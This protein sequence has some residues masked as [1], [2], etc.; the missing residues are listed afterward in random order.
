LQNN[1]AASLMLAQPDLNSGKSM[2]YPVKAQLKP[3]F[4]CE[5]WSR[6]C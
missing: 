5:I 6:F 4:S 2:G 3:D 1:S